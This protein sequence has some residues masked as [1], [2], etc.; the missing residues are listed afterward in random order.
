MRCS[1]AVWLVVLV[2]SAPALAQV[3]DHEDVD[4]VDL[5]SQAVMDA[6]GEQRWLFTHAS[7]GGNMVAG[8]DDLRG[9]DPTRYLLETVSVSYLSGEERAADP[10]DPTIAGTVYDCQRGN[11]GWSS[12]LTIFDSSVR[13][14]GWSYDAVDMAMDK[15]C[16]IDQTADAQSY[17]DM[18]VALESAYPSTVFVYTTIPLTTSEDANNVLRNDYNDAVRAHCQSTGCLLF[19]IADMEA[20][21]PTGVEHTFS[22]G[23]ETYQKLYDGYTSDGGHLDT[24]GRQRIAKG[25]YAVAATVEQREED[26][27]GVMA[28]LIRVL[29]DPSYLPPRN[30]DCTGDGGYA[31]DDM[32]CLCDR[33]FLP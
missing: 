24:V 14:S 5:L 27:A 18:M 30:A 25:W 20:H 12:K 11:P 2:L 9:S 26:G 4:G 32:P 6:I 17:I 28:D 31:E 3:V 16:Y 29:D 10:P 8:L 22:S 21:D 7:V 13:V 19:D 1:V 15:L 33:T 23:G